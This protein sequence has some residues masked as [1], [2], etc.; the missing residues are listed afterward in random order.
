MYYRPVVSDKLF[1]GVFSQV[2]QGFNDVPFFLRPAIALRGVPMQRFQGDG[3]TCAE[4]EVRWEVF[5]R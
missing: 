1:L 3:M 2:R 4:A 5:K